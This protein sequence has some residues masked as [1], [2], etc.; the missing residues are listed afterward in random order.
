M[1]Q[2]Q[3]KRVI[4]P[5]GNYSKDEVRQIARQHRVVGIK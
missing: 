5:L 3:L 4:L 1:T 2:P